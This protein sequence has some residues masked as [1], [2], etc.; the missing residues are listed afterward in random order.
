M[1]K[2]EIDFIKSWYKD[3]RWKLKIGEYD[4]YVVTIVGVVIGYIVVAISIILFRG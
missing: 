2:H 3:F 1:L 4:K